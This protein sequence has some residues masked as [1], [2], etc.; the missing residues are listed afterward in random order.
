MPLGSEKFPLFTAGALQ[1]CYAR[2]CDGDTESL[3]CRSLS[4]LLFPLAQTGLG[5]CHFFWSLP[6]R[7]CLEGTLNLRTVIWQIL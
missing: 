4:I 7:I 1:D 3:R 5:R 6:P 2:F